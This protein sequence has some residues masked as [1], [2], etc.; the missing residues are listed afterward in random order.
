MADSRSWAKL[1]DERLTDPAARKAFDAA[2][3]DMA[4][5][6]LVRV[7]RLGE[8]LTQSELAERMGTTQSAIA[9]L[10]AGGRTPSLDTLQSLTET[11]G[12]GLI[13]GFE[14][15]TGRVQGITLWS[16]QSKPGERIQEINRIS[17]K[18]LGLVIPDVHNPFYF[19]VAAAVE[20]EARAKGYLLNVANS[21]SDPEKEQDILRSLCER[22]VDGLL[23]IPAPG[24]DHQF[25]RSEFHMDERVVF[26]DRPPQNL[27]ADFVSSDNVGGAREAVE[28]LIRHGH[29]R[30]GMIVGDTRVW[31]DHERLQGYKDAL[32]AYKI[33]YDEELVM[34]LAN[35]V[36]TAE[37]AAEDLFQLSPP[38]TAIFAYNNRS[39]IGAF[40][41]I[42]WQEAPGFDKFELA[43][44]ALV[45]FDDFE[46]ADSLFLTV[47]AQD[48]K[49][50]GRLATEILL[51][52]LSGE[53][54]D[55]QDER[56]P[57]WLKPRG[58]GEKA[59]VPQTPQTAHVSD[60]PDQARFAQA[61]GDR[62]VLELSETPSS[63]YEWAA[64]A[65][66]P[67]EVKE[68][69]QSASEDS[70]YGASSIRMIQLSSDQDGR[71]EVTLVKRR[72]WDTESELERRNLVLEI[73]PRRAGRLLAAGQGRV[74]RQ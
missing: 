2:Q 60:P 29:R 52:R 50:L 70:D 73:V 46:L 69:T 17:T 62:L 38:P 42:K 22:R 56:I 43:D 32:A 7:L 36:S 48:A 57:T 39:A 53:E 25:L 13:I 33:P 72:P 8:G 37:K 68:F 28:H 20:H 61:A 40:R 44:M 41:A 66:P 35:R 47:E 9:R 30:I 54:F 49:K 18:L 64:F 24:A 5:G 1:R 34:S 4:L 26:I 23:V 14:N 27:E 12:E 10:E 59:P 21:D 3:R 71:Y 63:G 16:D 15:D 31:T 19:E 74:R 65:S 45:G 58:S 55:I 6:D 67:V 51:R 11:L